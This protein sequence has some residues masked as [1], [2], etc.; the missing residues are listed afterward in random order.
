M[1]FDKE[2]IQV[3]GELGTVLYKEKRYSE[4]LSIL[5]YA[6]NLGDESVFTK[7]YIGK[8]YLELEKYEDALDVFLELTKDTVGSYEAFFNLGLAYK[9]LDDY[10]SAKMAFQMA[11]FHDDENAEAHYKLGFA[12][13]KL[14]DSEGFNK[15]YA[16]LLDLDEAKAKQFLENTYKLLPKETRIIAA[17][18]DSFKI[19]PKKSN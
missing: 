9:G 15:Q 12:F 7:K 19:L 4:S 17:P 18:V 8:N 16:I 5:Q 2:N 10:K 13:Y 3:L 1:R 6:V 14:K 11:L